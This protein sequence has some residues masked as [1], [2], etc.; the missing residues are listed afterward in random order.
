MK[1]YI[2]FESFEGIPAAK[3]GLSTSLSQLPEK[4][5]YGFWVDRHGNFIVCKNV[6]SHRM[7]A[8][9]I[10]NKLKLPIDKSPHV[11][12]F[13]NGFMRVVIGGYVW[14][15]TKNDGPASHPQI[16]FL[17]YIKDLYNK[18]EII[19]DSGTQY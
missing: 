16:K 7:T 2:L 19:Q 11:I 5:P 10:I 8:I 13:D 1:Q 15:E 14:Y 3:L 6:Q 9:D 18:E 12:M 4:S 17:R